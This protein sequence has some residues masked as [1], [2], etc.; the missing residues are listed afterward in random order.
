MLICSLVNS[1]TSARTSSG[2]SSL[3]MTSPYYWCLWTN[4]NSTI[5]TSSMSSLTGFWHHKHR[6]VTLCMASA[7]LVSFSLSLSFICHALAVFLILPLSIFHLSHSIFNCISVLF[8]PLVLNN[9]LCIIPIFS[10]TD[11]SLPHILSVPSILT[12]LHH[13]LFLLH[14]LAIHRFLSEFV[15]NQIWP[16]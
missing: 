3:W 8:T 15:Q 9:I 5:H 7:M 10:I 4:S 1:L 12:F 2:L 6:Q 11:T 14:K 16:R 13:T